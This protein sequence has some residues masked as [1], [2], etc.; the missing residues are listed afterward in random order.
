MIDLDRLD[1][2]ESAADDVCPVCEGTG[3][4]DDEPDA[5]ECHTCG[6]E[7]FI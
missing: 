3:V 2:F 5:P 1:D 4:L 7:G 6:G